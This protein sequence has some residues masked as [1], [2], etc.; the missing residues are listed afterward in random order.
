MY[1]RELYGVRRHRDAAFEGTAEFED[2]KDRAGDDVLLMPARLL[3]AIAIIGTRRPWPR[4][5]R[6]T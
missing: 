3:L 5:R 1:E 2:E 4:K 6:Q